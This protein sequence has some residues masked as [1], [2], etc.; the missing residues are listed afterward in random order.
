[1]SSKRLLSVAV[2]SILFML[3]VIG[4]LLFDSLIGRDID[5]I[6]LPVIQAATD[7]PPA[8]PREDELERVEITRDNIQAV[9]STLHRPEI[10]SRNV[11]VESFWGDGQAVFHF[12]ISV[13]NG[14]TSIASNTQNRAERRTIVT[15]DRQ[16]IWYANESEP[17]VGEIGSPAN[18][19]RLADEW[20][21][22]PTYEDVINL[23]RDVIID[24]GYV[25]FEGVTS[26][27]VTYRSPLLDN[28]RTYYISIRH[29]LVIGAEVSDR[30]GEPVFSIRAGNPEDVDMDAFLL[31][32]GTNVLTNNTYN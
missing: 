21:M 8:D 17:F 9:I 25:D 30:N 12:H 23:D 6:P 4:F 3:A 27:F 22:L 14:V 18:P 11:F 2:F 15:H 31:P 16:Y 5:T 26:L 19:L 28:I 1:M 10:F 7:E 13:Y 24:A 32:D 29:G 20:H